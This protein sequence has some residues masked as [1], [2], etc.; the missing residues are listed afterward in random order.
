MGEKV[1]DMH[2]DHCNGILQPGREFGLNSE[3]CVGKYEFIDKK[4][5]GSP[6]I[7]NY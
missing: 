3:Y 2:R 1:I 4:Q 6:W 5:G 7:E